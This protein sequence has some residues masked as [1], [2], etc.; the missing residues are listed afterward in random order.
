MEIE[1]ESWT[2]TI[3]LKTGTAGGSCVY[4]TSVSIKCGKFLDLLLDLA[5]QE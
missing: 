4:G 3:W 1:W 2:Q 5:S